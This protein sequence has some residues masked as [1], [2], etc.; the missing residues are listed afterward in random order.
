LPLSTSITSLAFLIYAPLSVAAVTWARLGQDRWPWSLSL[1]WLGGAYEARLAA[2]LGLGLAVAA[3][4]VVITPWLV[5]RVTWARALQEELRPII[6]D[7]SSAEIAFL[8]LASG[9]AEELFFR[10]AMQPALGLLTTSLIFGVVHTGPKRVFLWWAVWAFA[11]GL[12]FGAIFEATG[13]L[14]GAVL[15]HA[16]IN[17]RNMMFM[18][19]H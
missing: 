18:K 11:M 2:S 17:Q 6:A 14:W 1:P 12:V 5:R 10:G 3:L 4:V 15:A 16:L 7:L 8:A 19:G 13:V 9:L